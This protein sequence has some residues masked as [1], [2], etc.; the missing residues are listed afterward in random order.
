[1]YIYECNEFFAYIKNF[2]KTAELYYHWNFWNVATF[3]VCGPPNSTQQKPAS[4]S[5]VV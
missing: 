2:F 4:N 3:P 1:M 5:A